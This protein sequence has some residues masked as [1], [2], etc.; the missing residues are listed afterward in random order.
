MQKAEQ[1]TIDLSN[2]H[3]SSNAMKYGEIVHAGGMVGQRVHTTHLK[4]DNEEIFCVKN[5]SEKKHQGLPVYFPQGKWV[6]V[7]NTDDTKYAGEGKYLNPGIYEG[8]GWGTPAIPMNIGS[9]DVT[10]FKRIG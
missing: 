3:D 7:I 10:Y 9:N 6:E 4:K 2:F 1:Y 5:L 8:K